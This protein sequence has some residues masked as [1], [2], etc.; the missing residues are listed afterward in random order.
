MERRTTRTVTIHNHNACFFSFVV[1]DIKDRDRT[2]KD[3]NIKHTS[4]K[5]YGNQRHISKDNAY[6]IPTKTNGRTFCVDFHT[7]VSIKKAVRTS[8]NRLKPSI[9]YS[10]AGPNIIL[11]SATTDIKPVYIKL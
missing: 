3:K 1:D 11:F 4:V 8:Q 9:P 10:Q 2:R 6:K 7:I 5:I